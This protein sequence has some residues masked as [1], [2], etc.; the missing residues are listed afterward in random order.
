MF[1]FVL[2]R[3]F[4]IHLPPPIPSPI[5]HILHGILS[6]CNALDC[7]GLHSSDLHYA[8]SLLH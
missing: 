3:G 6:F 2:L 1:G 5:P 4:G 7:I 8:A